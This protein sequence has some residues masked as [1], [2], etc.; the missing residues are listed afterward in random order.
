MC[1]SARSHAW[2]RMCV[3]ACVCARARACVCVC[4]CVCVCVC[5][6]ICVC[7]YVCVY[8]CLSVCVSKCVCVSFFVCVCLVF[9]CNWHQ[10]ALSS[11]ANSWIIIFL[12]H[13]NL[14]FSP[15][16]DEDTK[17]IF[18]LN[19]LRIHLNEWMNERF[20]Q[21]ISPA[22]KL[23]CRALG[24]I[25]RRSMVIEVAG[26]YFTSRKVRTWRILAK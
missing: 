20:L 19:S 4:W 8:V 16:K 26:N 2:A 14:Y 5:V 22:C 24:R 10:M 11:L 1:A 17:F 21:F 12:L 13:L 3:C 15:T 18:I 23:K 6:C 9:A 25:L 7:V